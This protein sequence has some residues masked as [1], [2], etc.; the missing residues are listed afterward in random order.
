M[1]YTKYRSTQETLQ[2]LDTL[3]LDTVQS[4]N[5][6]IIKKFAWEN[7][8]ELRTTGHLSM[9]K[10]L[11]GTIWQLFEEPRSSAMSHVTINIQSNPLF[12]LIDCIR[13]IS[14]VHLDRSNDFHVFHYS[15]DCNIC[16]SYIVHIRNNR[17]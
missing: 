7:D 5:E 15:F 16:S 14:I 4:T 2:V 6:D 1:T 12:R 11:M 13:L 9:R 10:R 17:L 8:N 3:N